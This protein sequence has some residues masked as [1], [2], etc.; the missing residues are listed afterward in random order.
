MLLQRIDITPA[1]RGLG[2][3]R[4][5][6]SN[7]LTVLMI[8]AGFV[9]IA[10]CVNTMNL[11][12]AKATAR[13][14]DFAVRLAIG[15]SPGRLMRQTLT[16]TLVLVGA[17]AAL[18][19]GLAYIGEN[20]LAAFLAEGNNI[21]LDISLNSRMAV[22]S[23]SIAL[24]SGIAVGMLPAVRAAQVDP[25]AGLRGWSRGLTGNQRTVRLGRALV[26]IQVAVSV[27]LVAGAGVFIRSLRALESVNLG[28]RTEGILTMEVTP[29]RQLFG[30]P[31]WIAS[32]ND[33]LAEVQRL[34]GVRSAG[35]A[36]MNPM[37]GRDRGAVVAVPGFT[38]RVETDKHIHLAAVSPD[39]FDALGLRIPF[40]RGFT[41]EDDEGSRRVAILNESATHFYFGQANPIGRTIELTNYARHDLLYE[42]VG[43][44]KDAKHDTLREAPAR[45]VYLPIPQHPDRIGRLAMAIRCSGDP[46]T[47][48]TTI[49]EQI[50]R[51]DSTLLI[52]NVSTMKNQVD[53]SLTRE[54][55]IAG[56]S[57]TFG[58]VALVLACIGLY[59]I[60]AYTVTRRTNE[61]GI[62]MALG[63]T[64]TAIVWQ[65]VREALG[66][67]AAGIV[68]GVPIVFALR[69]VT[70]TLIYGIQPVDPLAVAG[71]AVL[72]L[73]FGAAA[74]AGPS[75]AASSLDP[76]SALRRE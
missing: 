13:H 9:L 28:F 63:A 26:A 66:V 67:T 24:L 6:Y 65:I 55:L 32:Q 22:F 46:M 64:R 69:G 14:A 27:V 72:L 42:I 43:V 45:F 68:L 59:G 51:A 60:L 30:N 47:L 4:R 62:R 19:V 44:V 15:A 23:V 33:V 3:L 56:L 34:P 31:K 61:I 49:R 53:K 52:T 12:L 75:Q 57:S 17:G 38:A 48:A 8:L 37:T 71:A 20:A 76:I 18:G 35:W 21:L 41:R 2:G 50:R 70:K 39:Y 54:R 16:E 40:G 73:L 10:A 5:Q 1:G 74:A 11:T 7:A 25:A 36:T 58:I 29:E